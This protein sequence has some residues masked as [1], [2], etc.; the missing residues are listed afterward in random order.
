MIKKQALIFGVTGSLGSAIAKQLS[1]QYHV[2]GIARNPAVNK[3]HYLYHQ[4][5]SDFSE[6]SLSTISQSLHNHTKTFDLIINTI[7]ILHN[8]TLKPEKRLGDLSSASLSQ[9]L[10]ANTI[11]PGLLLK[12]F[13]G[14]MPRQAPSV[15]ATLSAKVGS[16]EDNRLGGWYGYRASKAAL[17]MLI[18]T[19]AIE[20]A[21]THKQAAIVA[22]HP[23]TTISPLS[24]PYTRKTPEDKLYT[25]QL[26]A[27]RIIQVL[28]HLKATDT[29]CFFNWSG[30]KLP[31]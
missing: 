14:L 17:N 29:G 25:P 27:E 21:R 8:S 3:P 11:I 1:E 9:Y 2:T 20:I 23:G 16:I 26:S 5:K 4:I 15:F 31:W 12:Y 19:A 7:G 13:Y 28:T 24:A 18:K 6:S 22:I 30:E 10:E